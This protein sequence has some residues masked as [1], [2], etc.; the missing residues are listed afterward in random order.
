MTA[1]Y[2]DQDILN[3]AVC[4][5]IGHI[6]LKLSEANKAYGE[7]AEALAELPPKCHHNTT[8]YF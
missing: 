4:E 7:A 2:P 3:A 6:F 8:C 1:L 5:K